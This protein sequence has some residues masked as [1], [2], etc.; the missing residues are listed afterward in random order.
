[1]GKEEFKGKDEV[2][3]YFNKEEYNHRRGSHLEVPV[4]SRPFK[5]NKTLWIILLDLGVIFLFAVVLLPLLRKPY[6]VKNFDG[7]RLKLTSFI[8]SGQ[9]YT[10]L[11]VTDNGSTRNTAAPRLINI[12][13]YLKDKKDLWEISDSLPDKDQT[14]SYSHFFK[15]PAAKKAYAEVRIGDD[16]VILRVK[17]EE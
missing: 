12:S 9:V 3:Y 2:T 4:K 5:D 1:M 11:D 10:V 13:F 8:S 7:Y 16:A 14:E 17:V 6:S 15:Q